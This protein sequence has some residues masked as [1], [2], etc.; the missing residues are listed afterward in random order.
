[1]P[2]KPKPTEIDVVKIANARAK[3]KRPWFFDNPET[4]KVLAITMAVAGELAVTRERLDTLERLL[5]S[6]GLLKRQAVEMF[7]PDAQAAGER[8]RWRQ[9]YIARVLRVV[10]QELEAI[11]EER[12]KKFAKTSPARK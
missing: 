10:T 8:D 4:E 9:A 6:Q 2:P 11:G 3:G 12:A 5:E 1:M 7:K